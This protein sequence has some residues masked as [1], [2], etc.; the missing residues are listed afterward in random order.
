MGGALALLVAH[1]AA[2][3]GHAIAYLAETRAAQALVEIIAGAAHVAVAAGLRQRLAAK[4]DA[5]TFDVALLDCRRDAPVGAA[6]IAHRREPA[7]EH[8][9][10]NADHAARG[11]ERRPALQLDEAVGPADDVHVRIAQPR[12]EHASADVDDGR[13][14]ALEPGFRNLLDAAVDDQNVLL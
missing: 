4:Q 5:R 6:G 13:A 2:H 3:F 11:V 1:R 9:F 8:A 14:R 12:H 7:V 10:Q